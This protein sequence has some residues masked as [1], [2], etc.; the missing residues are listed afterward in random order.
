MRK[1]TA[2][3][4]SIL[5]L[6]LLIVPFTV[7]T[8]NAASDD[9]EYVIKSSVKF[10]APSGHGWNL[11]ED[12]KTISLY[13][14]TLWQTVTLINSSYPFENVKTD[15]DGNSIAVLNMPS[16][17][18][19]ESGEY[20]VFYNVTSKPRDTPAISET[21]AG[22]LSNIPHNLTATYLNNSGTWMTNSNALRN[23]TFS[24]AG[25]NETKVL[26][27]VEN[28]V[29]WIRNNITYASHEF[30]FYPNE[31]LSSRS[32]DCDD[33]AILLVSFCRIVGIPAY[34][35]IGCIYMSNADNE[36]STAWD[37]HVENVQNHIAWHGWA[38]VYIPPWGWLPV[39]LTY[40]SKGN[41]LDAIETAVVTT[42]NVVQYMNVIQTNYVAQVREYKDFLSTH[43]FRI[44]AYDEITLQQGVDPFGFISESLNRNMAE[45]LIIAG[46]AV[47]CVG[48]L[49]YVKH[50]KSKSL[51][52]LP[53]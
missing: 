16:I 41:S 17:Q 53:A 30:P 12:D 11:T 1:T 39:D 26:V 28:F 50:R 36:S 45:V 33:Q 48:V 34:L 40:S 37:G 25:K 8:G 5:L 14:N 29:N 10:T 38:M 49:F 13:M 15:E 19:N 3:L 42:Q 2:I 52:N 31:T 18:A 21:E 46:V 7:E 20:T 6:T 51:E 44:W 43:G 35:Q 23:Q 32:G 47:C 27:I 24:L 9:K 22:T 4:L